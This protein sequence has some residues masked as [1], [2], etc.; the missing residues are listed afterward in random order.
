ML[1]RLKRI[2]PKIIQK[3]LTE[4]LNIEMILRSRL[5]GDMY[6]HVYVQII[7]KLLQINFDRKIIML[8]ASLVMAHN[9]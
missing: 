3:M 8:L 7:L 4:M 5:R 9:P 2:R 1:Q 6:I